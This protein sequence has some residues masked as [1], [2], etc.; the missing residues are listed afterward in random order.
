MLP[1][2]FLALIAHRASLRHVLVLSADYGLEAVIVLLLLQRC[3]HLLAAHCAKIC[4]GG[5]LVIGGVAPRDGLRLAGLFA[6]LEEREALLLVLFLGFGK[7]ELRRSLLLLLWLQ[8]IL[9]HR[10]E[11]YCQNKFSY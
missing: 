4:S 8:L 1:A 2:Q 5:L 9:I 3:S 7:I 11:H 6:L 10:H